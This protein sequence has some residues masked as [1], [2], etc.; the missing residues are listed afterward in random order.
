M[1][2]TTTT[3]FAL[4]DHY[5]LGRN[6]EL[7]LIEY[8]PI[9]MVGL[10]SYNQSAGI[11]LLIMRIHHYGRMRLS[12]LNSSELYILSCGKSL[13]LRPGPSPQLRM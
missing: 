13:G 5:I 8:R 10:W 11:D 2:K 7:M 12:Q 9:I 4:S 6:G 3:L 1:F